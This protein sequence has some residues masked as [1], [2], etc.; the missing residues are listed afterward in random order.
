MT[1]LMLALTLSLAA[2]DDG[3]GPFVR[4]DKLATTAKVYISA[5]DYPAI[6]TDQDRAKATGF[7]GYVEGVADALS[8]TDLCF[9]KGTSVTQ[10]STMVASYVSQ[11]PEQWHLAASTLVVAA[12]KPT[13]PCTP[14][15]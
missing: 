7:S 1:V 4:G 5:R 10:V 12:L 15:R 3:R 11:H 14:G 8:G 2:A 13:F 6:A 9:P